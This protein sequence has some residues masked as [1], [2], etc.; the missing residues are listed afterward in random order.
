MI[1]QV[2]F[3]NMA[4]TPVDSRVVEAML[5]HL[6]ETYGNPLNLHD[7]GAKTAAAIEEA[8]Q[9]VAALIGANTEEIIFTSCGSESNNCAIKGIARANEKKGK[10]VITS[11]IEHFSVHYPLK[12]LE[13][14]GYKVT[15]LPVDQ[16]GLIDPQA[17]AQ[18]L[19]PE[20]TLVTLTHASNEIGTIEPIAEIGKVIRTWNTE[21]GTQIIFHIDAVQTA[22]TIPVNVGDLGVDALTLSANLFYGPTGIAALY[23][24]KGTRILPFILGGTQE[25]GKRAGTHNIPGIV[26]LGKAAELAQAEMA[27]RAAKLMPL[28]DK[29]LRSIP[30]KIKDYFV[31]GHPTQRLPGHASG[32][33]KYIEGESMSMFLNMEGIAVS[34][35]SACVS[36]ALKASHVVLALGVNAADVH[37]SL[38][39]SLGKDNFEEEVDYVLAKFPPIVQRLREMSPL[40]RR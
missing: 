33:V 17:V 7:F 26:G 4:N 3:D 30:E 35:G 28:R 2:Y 34:T 31:T 32:Y 40:G 24:K 20:T 11:A 29:L 18:A 10:Q 23:L 15:Y 38:V 6:R 5:P 25:E 22:G 14:E 37:G 1:E 39:F 19:T 16:F 21:H 36:K 27:A 8:R 12:E 13:K 9:K